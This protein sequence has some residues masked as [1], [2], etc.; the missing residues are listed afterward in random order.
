MKC[1]TC[2]GLI[3]YD[4]DWYELQSWLPPTMCN[5]CV[6]RWYKKLNKVLEF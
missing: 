4:K 3:L 1:D 2:N 6:D 5:D